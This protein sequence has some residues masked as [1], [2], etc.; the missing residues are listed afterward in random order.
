MA[1]RISLK[2]REFSRMGAYWSGASGPTYLTGPTGPSS[3]LPHGFRSMAAIASRPQ[4]VEIESQVRPL[5]N[6]NLVVCMKV[7][8]TAVKAVAK[9][10]QH[11]IG[12]RVTEAGLPEHSDNLRLPGAVNASPAVALEAEDPQP[13]VVS[14]RI[15]ARWPCRDVRRVHAVARGGVTRRDRR[16]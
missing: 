12:R 14:H 10:G 15:R 2:T 11:S 6:R 16:W 13:A 9:L 4:I 8:L 3:R 5:R 7:A 1:V